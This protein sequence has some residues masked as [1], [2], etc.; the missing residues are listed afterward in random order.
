MTHVG[1]LA[2]TLK[3][4]LYAFPSLPAQFAARVFRAAYSS[5]ER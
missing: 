4:S 5:E 3:H 1:E 2:V